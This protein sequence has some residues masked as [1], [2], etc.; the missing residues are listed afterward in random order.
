MFL[1]NVPKLETNYE[2]NLWSLIEQGMGKQ[3]SYLKSSIHAS[4]AYCSRFNALTL[5]KVVENN[6]S[7]EL[8]LFAHLGNCIEEFVI[9]SL[10][11]SDRLVTS[12]YRC[13]LHENDPEIKIGGLVDII[14]KNQNNN[15]AI[16]EIKST[17]S[18]I[19]KENYNSSGKKSKSVG[20]S[21]SGASIS[22]KTQA[23]IYAGMTGIDDVSILYISRAVVEEFNGGIAHHIHKIDVSDKNLI[24]RFTDL[25]YAYYC[26]LEGLIPEIPSNFRKTVECKNCDLNPTCFT[27]INSGY[28]NIKLLEKAEE[29]A[30]LFIK[31]RPLRLQKF[32]KDYFKSD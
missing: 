27:E 20:I 21:E 8:S 5:N 1:Q 11:K 7:P 3:D 25:Y 14:Y 30:K 32:I 6:S 9:N 4:S 15:L 28:T 26:A 2:D 24:L 12:Q 22:H 18:I 23:E 16:L 17:K 29:S 19:T 31:N 13:E 10:I